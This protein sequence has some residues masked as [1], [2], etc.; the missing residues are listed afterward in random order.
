MRYVL[1]LIVALCLALAGCAGAPVTPTTQP[2]TAPVV[3]IPTVNAQALAAW[4]A[5]LDEALSLA[6]TYPGGGIPPK[7]QKDIDTARWFIA[8][9]QAVA[10][11]Q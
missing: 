3:G 11:A 6:S 5:K 8:F 1:P 10:A 2:T 7:V 4:S 9:Y